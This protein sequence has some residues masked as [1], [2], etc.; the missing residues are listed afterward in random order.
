MTGAAQAHTE[1]FSGDDEARRA[2]LG[3]RLAGTNIDET[4]FLATD[5]LNHFNEIVML[6]DMVPDMPDIFEEASAW[7]PKDYCDHFRDSAFSDKD[8]A[9]AAYEAAP[10]IHRGPFDE[11]IARMNDA[12]MS[13]LDRI[14]AA[15]ADGDEQTVRRLAT[16]T[17]RSVQKLIDVASAIIH[18]TTTTME[19]DAIDALLES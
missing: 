7:R 6:L 14:E 17:S 4:T 5:Y 18:G 10:P 8:L 15:I 12:I 9:I 1:V 16:E 2:A 3:A 11:T 19:Q 13:T